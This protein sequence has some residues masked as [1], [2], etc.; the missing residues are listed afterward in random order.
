MLPETHFSVDLRA[1]QRD[2][3]TLSGT[4]MYAPGPNYGYPAPV[5]P[6]STLGFKTTCTST[7]WNQD[8][9]G[10]PT[11]NL[12]NPLW[13]E[14]YVGELGSGQDFLRWQQLEWTLYKDGTTV[15]PINTSCRYIIKF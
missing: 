5:N 10:T 15:R 9:T 3:I 14:H 8:S 2:G 7:L 12:H 11:F 1:Y 4:D 13:S 6:I